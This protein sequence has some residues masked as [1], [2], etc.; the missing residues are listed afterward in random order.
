MAR[1]EVLKAHLHDSAPLARVAA[2]AGVPLRTVQRWL[3]CR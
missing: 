2:E 3:G 1:F